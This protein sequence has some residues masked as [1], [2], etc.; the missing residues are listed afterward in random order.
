MGTEEE[1]HTRKSSDILSMSRGAS[2]PGRKTT[3]LQQCRGLE[4][5]VLFLRPLDTVHADIHVVG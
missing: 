3:S 4:L 1:G 5:L 2:G